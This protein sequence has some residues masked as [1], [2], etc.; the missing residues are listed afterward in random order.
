MRRKPLLLCIALAFN[1][2][3]TIP[4]LAQVDSAAVA[5]PHDDT[6]HAA[7]IDDL[8]RSIDDQQKALDEQQKKLDSQKDALQQVRQQVQALAGST[9]ETPLTPATIPFSRRND[10]QTRTRDDAQP[11]ENWEGSF[12]LSDSKTRIR[13]G[14]FLELDVIYDTNAILSKGQFIPDTIVTRNPTKKQGSDG[15]S[16]FSVSPSRFYIET[17]TPVNQK[18]VKTYLSIDMYG[19]ELGVDPQPRLRQGYV[20]LSDILFGGDLLIGQAWS[21]TTDLEAAPELLDFRGVDNQFGSL[22]PQV[23]WTRQVA[24]G[25]RL[26]LAAE[27]PNRHIIEGADSLTRLPDGIIAATW[28]SDSFNLMASLLVTDLRASFN[29]GPVQSAVGVGG[30]VSGKVK[31]PFGAYRDDFLFSLTYGNGIGSHYQNSHPDAVYNSAN[32]SLELISNYGVTLGYAH[33]WSE[34]LNSSFTYCCIEIDNQ[35]SQSPNSLQATEYSSG[36]LIWDVN[37]HWMLGIEGLWGKRKDKDSVRA[38]DFRTQF[39]S[40]YYY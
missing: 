28:D 31:L 40:R 34:R 30:S 19:D 6:E 11:L 27:T 36:N 13:T 23:R 10:L 7:K 5:T 9:E 15:Q 21:T 29:N 14:G 18:R 8:R 38:T 32:G 2:F 33:G 20:E 37:N 39:T 22:L 17:R 1:C 24:A 25:V 12:A 4:A 26:M 3:L 16:S 35:E